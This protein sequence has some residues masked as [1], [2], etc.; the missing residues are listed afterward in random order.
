MKMFYHNPANSSSVSFQAGLFICMVASDIFQIRYRLYSGT[1]TIEK[2]IY[3]ATLCRNNFR[4][5]TVMI[6]EFIY[7]VTLCRNI[8]RPNTVTIE[9]FI[10][11][12]CS[13]TDGLFK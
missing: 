5:N 1:V 7:V 13:N 3:V 10:Y 12:N 8:F 9:K 2:F 6:E 11:V 4:S